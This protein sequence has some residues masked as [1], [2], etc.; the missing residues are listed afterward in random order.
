MTIDRAVWSF[1]SRPFDGQTHGRWGSDRFH[2]LTW[3]LS[4]WTVRALFRSTTLVTDDAGA[5][6]L[7]DQLGL[8]FDSISTSLEGLAGCD[9]RWWILG[10]LQAYHEQERPFLH[11]DNDVFLW[12]RLPEALLTC[13]LVGQN[14]EYAPTS[15]A[16]FYK[17]SAF[18]ADVAAGSGLLPPEW[19]A[20]LR[21][22]GATA[23]C[24]G[25]FG[26]CDNEAIS[27][28]A[29]RAMWTIQRDEN[30]VVWAGLDVGLREQVLLEQYYLAAYWADVGN[31]I[32]H[33]PEMKYLFSSLEEAYDPAACRRLGFT[34][35][36][37]HAKR[38]PA[39]EQLVADRL[40][41]DYPAAYQRVDAVAA[42]R[43]RGEQLSS[44]AR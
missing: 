22:G 41:S 43:V 5:A 7:I 39:L 12:R 10:K 40:R 3:A 16:T 20:Y 26:G 15:D 38:S 30:D 9:E 44:A 1:W 21:A 19:H 34:H 14:P 23:V 37:A 8:P 35:L 36:I 33:R 17:P 24:T 29:E 31:D 32:G 13:D 28:Y 4:F 2:L 18:T 25:I 6:L 11:V 42:R 27:Q